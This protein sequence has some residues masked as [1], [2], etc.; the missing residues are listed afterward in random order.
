MLAQLEG[1]GRGA[2]GS[3][4]AEAYQDLTDFLHTQNMENPTDWL[5]L[6]LRRNEMLGELCGALLQAPLATIAAS[7]KIV[8]MTCK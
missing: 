7:Q 8:V 4:N 6:L 5:A 3:Y 1:S 2:I